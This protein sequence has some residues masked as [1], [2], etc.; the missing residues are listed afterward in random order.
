MPQLELHMLRVAGVA[1][2]IVDSFTQDVD[3]DTVI[4][5]CLLHDIG[6]IVKFDLEKYP[7][8]LKPK[9]HVYWK[10]VQDE[11]IKK[12][13]KSDY[14]ATYKIL[15]EMKIPRK[16]FEHMNTMEFRKAPENAKQD[17]FEIKIT[18]YADMRV[19]PYGITSMNERFDE[20]KERFMRNHGIS[21]QV[22][23][24]YKSGAQALEE[25]IFYHTKISPKDITDTN[26]M[27]L[28]HR[29]KNYNIKLNQ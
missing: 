23:N 29:L 12:Y 6:N 27:R 15:K 22:F 25:Q 14:K 8:N 19:A 20:V 4:T 13:G 24:K 11:F 17:N 5:V 7:E 16:L 10:K 18:Q 21:N 26:V 2:L 3:K 1:T 9:G 28:I